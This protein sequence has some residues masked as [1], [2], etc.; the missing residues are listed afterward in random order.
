MRAP[1]LVITGDAALD[2]VV[3]VRLTR[4]YLSI[5]PHAAHATMER[6]GHLGVI[7]RAAAF[8]DIVAPFV[9]RSADA[10]ADE[11]PAREQPDARRRVV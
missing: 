5:W 7:T 3:P 6:S 2:R 1:V 4:E 8:A 11:L 10:Q 9:E